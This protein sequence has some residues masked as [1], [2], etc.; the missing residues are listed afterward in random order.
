ME[1]IRAEA[2]GQKQT[3]YNKTSFSSNQPQPMTNNVSVLT[4][5]AGSLAPTPMQRQTN[6]NA[7]RRMASDLSYDP[8]RM[9]SGAYSDGRGTFSQGLSGV[10]SAGYSAS[11][12]GT[13]DTVDEEP[14]ANMT[15]DA[16][17]E[18]PFELTVNHSKC[19]LFRPH[20]L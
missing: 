1:Q 10:Y 9:A 17:N 18:Q 11:R 2:K 3:V 6:A 8:K 19:V 4:P 14:A 7:S 13:P 12:A 5:S 15:M 20:L 16:G